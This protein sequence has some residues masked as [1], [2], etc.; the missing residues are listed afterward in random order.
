[1][2]TSECKN[3]YVQSNTRGG[4]LSSQRFYEKWLTF[5]LA[6]IFSEEKCKEIILNLI[7]EDFSKAEYNDHPE[8]PEEILYIFGKD[9]QLLP[10]YGRNEETVALYIKFNKQTNMY[11]IVVSFHKQE[12]PLKYQFK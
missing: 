12:Y 11:V 7:A 5:R 2:L 10:R 6:N 1:M 4:S 9:V 3:L 8:H